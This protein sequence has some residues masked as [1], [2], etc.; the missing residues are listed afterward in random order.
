MN[1]V[2][3]IDK[4]GILHENFYLLPIGFLFLFAG[5]LSF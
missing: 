4:T 1:S 3:Y 2:E 5:I